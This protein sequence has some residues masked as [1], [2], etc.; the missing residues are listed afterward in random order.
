MDGQSV[1]ERV[2][3]LHERVRAACDRA[4]RD[5]NDVHILAVSK[6]HSLH[7]VR[8]AYHEGLRDFAENYAQEAL[9]KIEQLEN[10]PVHWH[11]IG[12]IQSNKVKFLAG[13]FAAIHSVDRLSVARELDRVSASAGRVQDIF[14]QANI[15]GESQKGGADASDLR[16]LTREILGLSHLRMLGLMVMP[17]FA[18]N[19][20]DM[21]PHFARARVLLGELREELQGEWAG[22]HPLDQLSMGTTQDFEVAIEEGATWIRIGTDIFGPREEILK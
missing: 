20:E 4:G 5:V 19:S 15:A 10:L 21:R 2:K 22:R 16:K 7:R 3:H 8:E 12:R 6:F 17:P 9:T 1:A 18:D 14:L 11:F 13:R